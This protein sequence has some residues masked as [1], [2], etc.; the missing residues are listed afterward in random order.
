MR[1]RFY[2]PKSLSTSCIKTLCNWVSDKNMASE[3]FQ[4]ML[5]K[6][7]SLDPNNTQIELLKLELLALK[8]AQ[9]SHFATK[10]SITERKV[11]DF[12]GII[13]DTRDDQHPYI[14]SLQTIKT[15]KFPG[16][17]MCP[18]H[19]HDETN[20]LLSFTFIE[21]ENDNLELKCNGDLLLL[22]KNLDQSTVKF[23]N[24]I[25]PDTFPQVKASQ[26]GEKESIR[27]TKLA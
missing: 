10:A 18:A 25:L 13:C 1:E 22:L 27:L 4:N 19:E 17:F 15:I 23:I 11:K 3:K 24:A 20:T 26:E 2:Q 21:N 7:H 6:L 16:N 12:T 9:D 8:I 14:Y 5:M